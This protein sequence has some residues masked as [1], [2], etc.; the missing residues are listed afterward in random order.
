[1]LRPRRRRR[2]SHAI[3]VFSRFV[4]TAEGPMPSSGPLDRLPGDRTGKRSKT[5]SPT[6]ASHAAA[7]F[8]AHAGAPTRAVQHAAT[9]RAIA[10]SRQA[11]NRSSARAGGVVPAS[12]SRSQSSAGPTPPRGPQGQ[13]SLPSAAGSASDC[14]WCLCCCL[15][16]SCSRVA[17]AV[18]PAGARGPSTRRATLGCAV[19]VAGV[20]YVQRGTNHCKK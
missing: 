6:V 8:H 4:P 3:A 12:R 18:P 17:W 20:V 1:M 10:R 5:R 16:S 11:Q 7:Q 13:K 9:G 2:C 19:G 15:S 14:H